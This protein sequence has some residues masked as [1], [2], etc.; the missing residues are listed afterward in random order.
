M[1]NNKQLIFTIKL[2]GTI[3]ISSSYKSN[4]TKANSKGAIQSLVDIERCDLLLVLNYQLTLTS[5]ND[6]GIDVCQVNKIRMLTSHNIRVHWKCRVGNEN[7]NE[8]K[9]I[10]T[11]KC[12]LSNHHSFAWYL[13]KNWPFPLLYNT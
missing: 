3:N 13:T 7:Q 2:N 11:D 9:L 1:N 12:K 8:N 4:R 5:I 10:N 6:G